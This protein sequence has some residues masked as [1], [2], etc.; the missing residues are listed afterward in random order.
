[1]TLLEKE[2]LDKLAV[3]KQDFCISIY[4]PTH[5]SGENKDS[6][7]RL[8]NQLSQI[9]D[10][11][12]ELG[13]KSS[14]LQHYTDPIYRL[15][16]DSSF[17]R[18]LSKTLVILKSQ[19]TFI[20]QPFSF[21]TREFSM[22]SDR[23]YLLPLLDAYRP[24]EDFYI[25]QLSLNQNQLFHANPH[26][27]T[28]IETDEHLPQNIETVIGSDV[29]Q[30]SLQYRSGQ[31]QSGHGLYHG[32]GEGKEDKEKEIL[33]YLQAVSDGVNQLIGNSDR[34]LVI[35]SVEHIYAHFKQLS[36]YK[37]IFP[38]CVAGNY[39]NGNSAQLHAKACSLLKSYLDQ[40]RTNR[41][42]Q[43][44]EISQQTTTDLNE[45]LLAASGGRIATLSIKKGV[46][47]WGFFDV[48][49]GIIKVHEEKEPLDYCLLDDAAKSTFRQGGQVFIEQEDELPVTTAAANAVLRY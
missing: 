46:N 37:A 6:L 1:M 16:Q 19:D 34:P 49:N 35:A 22:V 9:E 23:F 4:I 25:L 12:L 14:E 45:L 10:S 40:N 29:R 24:N 17:W 8:K 30:K 7:I 47:T 3:K 36:D 32:K 21:E 18:H 43:Y 41:K 15:L 26:G 11:L 42:K 44:A 28:Q 48:E 5:Q 38:K 39:D 31:T 27:Y 33:K 2:K 20:C 13:V